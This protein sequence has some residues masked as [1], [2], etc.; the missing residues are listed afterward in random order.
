MSGEWTPQR[1]AD[2]RAWC[3]GGGSKSREFAAALDEIE[4]LREGLREARITGLLFAARYRPD[5]KRWCDEQRA[6][7]DALLSGEGKE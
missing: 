4:R 5:F 6:R 1:H 2:A 3:K 7:I